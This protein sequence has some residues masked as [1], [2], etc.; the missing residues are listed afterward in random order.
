MDAFEPLP[1][2]LIL[3]SV[4]D[5][6]VANQVVLVPGLAVDRQRGL[7]F[8]RNDLERTLLEFLG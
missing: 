7:V 8:V 1:L 2:L 5:R 6:G 4:P 3:D